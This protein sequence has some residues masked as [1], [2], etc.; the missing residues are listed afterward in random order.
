MSHWKVQ[1]SL[2]DFGVQQ[3]PVRQNCPAAQLPHEPP[4]PSSPHRLRPQCG[5]QVGDGGD[6][7]PGGCG[8]L[9]F[10]W[11]LCLAPAVSSWRPPS[12]APA[13]TNP[14]KMSRREGRRLKERTSVSKRSESTTHFSRVGHGAAEHGNAARRRNSVVGRITVRHPSPPSSRDRTP[15]ESSELCMRPTLPY[16]FRALLTRP[17]PSGAGADTGGAVGGSADRRATTP[18]NDAR[19]PRPELLLAVRV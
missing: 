4:Q 2:V 15:A 6:G 1:M 7:G 12:P 17:R 13:P 11:C 5:V 3:V 19:R 8:S 14:R 16:V 10:L 18:Q 9:C